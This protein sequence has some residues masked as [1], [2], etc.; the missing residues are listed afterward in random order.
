MVSDQGEDHRLVRAIATDW[1]TAELAPKDRVLCE[2][3]EQLTRDS[4]SL[5]EAD[6]AT[7][8]DH[9]FNDQAIHD[10]TQVVAYFNYINRVADGL[11]I[12]DED[13]LTEP[14]TP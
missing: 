1:R 12:D 2:L 4:N 14:P 6:V 10:F 7:L 11:G 3:A 9:G 5:S 8:R 13:W